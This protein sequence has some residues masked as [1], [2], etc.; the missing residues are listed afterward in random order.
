MDFRTLMGVWVMSAFIFSAAYSGNLKGHLTTPTFT[1]PIKSFKDVADSGL[2]WIWVDYNTAWL[3]AMAFHSD[4]YVRK[5]WLERDT[6]IVDFHNEVRK[7]K[8]LLIVLIV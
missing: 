6:T 2:P 8:I 5:M 4:P 1:S 3:K 7:S